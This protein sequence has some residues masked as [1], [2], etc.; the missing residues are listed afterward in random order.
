FTGQGNCAVA[1]APSDLPVDDLGGCARRVC[2]GTGP[3]A[4]LA[5]R[6]G[7]LWWAAEP[8]LRVQ[9][10]RLRGPHNRL[11]AMAAA[12]VTLARGIDPD[13]V[14]EALRTFAG[15]PHRLEEVAELDGV[16]YI[17]DSKATNVDAT[18]MALASFDR[19]I[20]LI[21]GGRGKGGGY[22]AL[23]DPVAGRCAGVYLIGEAAD[24]M[25]AALEGAGP[26][27]HR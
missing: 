11:N 9:E 3:E 18:L 21:L 26:P 22:G 13:A 2:F 8:L 23:R 24:A 7:Q 27:V 15:V 19:P 6:A 14:R 25:A 1:V 12:A 4:E 16:L 10:I 5:D 20:H 17:N